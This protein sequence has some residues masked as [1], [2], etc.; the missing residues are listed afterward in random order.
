MARVRFSR[1]L[2][3]FLH[4]A[5]QFLA[6][7]TQ[8]VETPRLDALLQVCTVEVR[9]GSLAVAL[10]RKLLR[11]RKHGWRGSELGLRIRLGLGL[12]I[13]LGRLVRGR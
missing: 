6:P 10:G 11:Y 5:L 7:C 1:P 3:R 12:G 9:V 4:L 2:L 13:R 8:G